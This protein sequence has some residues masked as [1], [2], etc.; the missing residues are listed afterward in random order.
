MPDSS[1]L[2]LKGFGGHGVG[3]ELTSAVSVRVWQNG[4]RRGECAGINAPVF[5][6]N[7]LNKVLVVID[8]LDSA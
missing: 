8:A 1:G 3:L 4:D 5:K 6:V 7:V 2:R